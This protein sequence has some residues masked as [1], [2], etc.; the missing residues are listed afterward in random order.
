MC[1]DEFQLLDRLY[2]V[3][4]I[5]D[6]FQYII[7]KHEDVNPPIRIYVNE[8][9]NRIT[10]KIKTGYCLEILKSEMMKLLGSFE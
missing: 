10:F 5:Q 7:Q 9:E 8:I 4:H 1:N 3:S 2:T 6:Y